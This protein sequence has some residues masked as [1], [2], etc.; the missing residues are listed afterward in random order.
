MKK[1]NEQFLNPYYFIPL[2]KKKTPAYE[3][4][5]DKL[6]GKITYE[7]V[8]RTPLFI[9][10]TSCDRA[11]GEMEKG[12][13]SYDFYS[14]KEL[15]SGEALESEYT[16]VIPGS[17]VR[18]MIRSVYEAVTGSCMSVINDGQP[19]FYRSGMRDYFQPGLLKK[20]EDKVILLTAKAVYWKRDDAKNTD[21][22]DGQKLYYKAEEYKQRWYVTDISETETTWNSGY[23]L[24]GE[25]EP[26]GVKFSTKK[27]VAIFSPCNKKEKPLIF[28][29]NLQKDYK[30]L[31]EAYQ[32][33]S[34][35]YKAY[36]VAYKRFM[37]DPE[38]CYF[39]VYFKEEKS[40]SEKIIHIAPAAI[41]KRRYAKRIKDILGE[42]SPCHL[43]KE[44]CPACD[45]FGMVEKGNQIRAKA[46]RLRFCDAVFQ[47]ENSQGEIYCQKMNLQELASPHLSNAQMYLKRPENAWDWNYDLWREKNGKNYPYKAELNGRKFYWH[48]VNPDIQNMTTVKT[49]KNTERNVTVRPVTDGVTFIGEIFFNGITRKQ[50]DQ[51]IYLCNISSPVIQKKDEEKQELGYKLGMGKPIGLGSI[52]MRVKNIKTRCFNPKQADF[53][54]EQ[55]IDFLDANESERYTV[56][57]NDAGFLNENHIRD[58]FKMLMD[59]NITKDC[60]ISYP[61]M[62]VQLEKMDVKVKVVNKNGKTSWKS[63]G[64]FQWF[65]ANKDTKE[66]KQC[67]VKK[68]EEKRDEIKLPYL[69]VTAFRK[70]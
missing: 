66:N 10:N 3:E 38:Q 13:K 27:N 48:H 19:I 46:S 56:S 40:F 17:E 2:P 4:E 62:D 53:Y 70:R 25:L 18:G 26:K 5:K 24:R 58:W 54:S 23:L 33:D 55:T 65:V 12:H 50:L 11:F 31:L 8:T 21:Y 47:K 28:D 67:L 60:T 6:T 45:L 61:Y 29:E 49:V 37:E 63:L 30:R 64:G 22:L 52:Q 34:G 7:I 43:D 39:P 44:L 32:K 9:P 41:P 1:N 42:M 59:L 15:K 35:S 68:E 69:K 57:Y 16:P 36:A 51:L 14:Y 20:E